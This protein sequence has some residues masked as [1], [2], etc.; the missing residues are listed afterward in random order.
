M[1]LLGT[2]FFALFE[3]NDDEIFPAHKSWKVVEKGFRSS[4]SFGFDKDKWLKHS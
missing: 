2:I 3:E 4:G 1:G